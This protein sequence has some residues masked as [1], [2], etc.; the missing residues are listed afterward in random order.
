M[1]SRKF[2]L[3][4][5]GA[6]LFAVLVTTMNVLEVKAQTGVPAKQ[7][8]ATTATAQTAAKLLAPKE[9][10]LTGR[11]VDIHC[12]MTGQ[13]PSEDKAK[14][15]ADC[16]KA[17]VPAALETPTGLILLGQGTGGAAKSLVPLAYQ[18]VE[19]KGQLFEKAGVKYLDITS[20]QAKANAKP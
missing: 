10:T 6:A 17:G 16:I 1:T 3:A 14:C 5:C 12:F 11:V 13:F 18:Q 8:T 4:A 7:P 15:T 9:S 2:G 19:V 20:I